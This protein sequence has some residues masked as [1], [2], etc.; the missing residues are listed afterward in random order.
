[1]DYCVVVFFAVQCNYMRISVQSCQGT[2]IWMYLQVCCLFVCMLG[3]Y[4]C[5]KIFMRI[6]VFMLCIYFLYVGAVLCISHVNLSIWSSF[7]RWI[8]KLIY[9]NTRNARLIQISNKLFRFKFDSDR[10]SIRHKFKLNN[11]Q[12]SLNFRLVHFA[13]AGFVSPCL[14]D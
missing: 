11:A 9:L 5:I 2:L 4:K 6:H 10:T 14:I 8:V 1:M 7:V 13:A 12:T 3:L